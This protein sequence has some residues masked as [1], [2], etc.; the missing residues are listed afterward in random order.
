MTGEV[1]GERRNEGAKERRSIVYKDRR[2]ARYRFI[3]TYTYGK[4][5]FKRAHAR[6]YTRIDSYSYN[7]VLKLLAKQRLRRGSW[8]FASVRDSTKPFGKKSR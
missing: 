2:R 7:F 6:I 1:E 3:H 8:E 4:H 5:T